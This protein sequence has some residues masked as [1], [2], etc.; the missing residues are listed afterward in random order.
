MNNTK[1]LKNLGVSDSRMVEN[2]I[3]KNMNIADIAVKH[4]ATM[5]VFMK[6]GMH[7]IGC[8]AAQ[9]ETLEQG[10]AAHN[11]DVDAMVNDLNASLDKTAKDSKEKKEE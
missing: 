7:C 5:E 3:T 1:T 8:I 4:P 10:C 9:F 2:K 6:Y 11:I